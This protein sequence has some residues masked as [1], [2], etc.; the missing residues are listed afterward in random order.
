MIQ[1]IR[2]QVLV[3]M[4][5]QEETSKGGIIV[6]ESFRSE[7]DMGKVISVGNGTQKTPMQFNGGETIFRTHEWGEPIENNGERFYL[8]EQ[9][10][11]L[12]TV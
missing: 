12:A 2:N 4:I 11:I 6:P 7:S 5:L 3:K 1:P 9:D 8:M 10:T